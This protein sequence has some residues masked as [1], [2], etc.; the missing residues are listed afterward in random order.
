MGKLKSLKKVV[1]KKSKWLRGNPK[2]RRGT[3]VQE[4]TNDRVL[5]DSG[6]KVDGRMCCLG[7]WS[8]QA[9]VSDYNLETWKLPCQLPQTPPGITSKIESALVEINDS[10]SKKYPDAEAK[11]KALNAKLKELGSKTRFVLE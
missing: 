9:G 10:C 7:F 3:F 2:T 6:L 1:I 4:A 11:V 8:Q 5:E